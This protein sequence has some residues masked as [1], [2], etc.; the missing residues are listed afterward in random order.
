MTFQVGEERQDV[1]VE[2]LEQG[3]EILIEGERLAVRIESLEDGRLHIDLAGRQLTLRPV[4]RGNELTLLWGGAA[5]RLRLLDPQIE[6]GQSDSAATRV[7]A[8]MPGRVAQVQVMPGQEV[9]RGDVLLVL[10]A[11]KMEHTLYA[12]KD[13]RIA[14]VHFAVGEQV[15]EGVELVTFAEEASTEKDESGSH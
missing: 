14:D 2:Y 7:L 4:W 3:L 12:P 15:E 13:G 9:S 8:P 11:M 10:E 6:A 1:A 5:Y